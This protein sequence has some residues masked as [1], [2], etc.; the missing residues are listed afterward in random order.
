MFDKRL[1]AGFTLIEVMI[2]VA[3]VAILATIALPNYT[4]HVRRGRIAEAV[5]EV[6]DLRVRMERFYQDNRTFVGSPA[7]A[8]TTVNSFT[9]SCSAVAAD[10]YTLQAVGAGTMA[11]FTF[12]V[13]ELNARTSTVT[14]VSGWA[15]NADCWVTR[16]GGQC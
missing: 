2:V 3:I 12:T 16:K 8:S 7:C 4:D 6:S 13:N 15:G 14:G 10:T 9:F 5:G 1:S 11:G